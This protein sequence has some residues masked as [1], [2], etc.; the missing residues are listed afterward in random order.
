MY[1]NQDKGIVAGLASGF[2]WGTP[3][4]VPMI[5]HTY[6]ALDITLGRFLFF[7]IFSLI[8][9]KQSWQLF[10]SFNL[11]QRLKLILLATTGFWLYTLTLYNAPICQDH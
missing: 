5:L 4:V 2:F 3:F 1:V 6:T 7:G 8:Y 11:Q 9:A 10:I